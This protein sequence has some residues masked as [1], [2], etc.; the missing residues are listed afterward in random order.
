MNQFMWLMAQI[1]EIPA[2]AQQLMDWLPSI[3]GSIIVPLVGAIKKFFPDF[4]E[5]LKQYVPYEHW[6]TI[7]AAVVSFGYVYFAGLNLT[8]HE[9]INCVLQVVGSSTIL[10]ALVNKGKSPFTK[11]RGRKFGNE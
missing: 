6:V 8:I 4:T 3:V 9:T 10:F 11:M 5:W 7:I 2:D 1:T